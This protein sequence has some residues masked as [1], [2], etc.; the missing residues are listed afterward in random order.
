MYKLCKTEHSASR[1]REME[2]GLLQ[3][4][5]IKCYEDI[6]VS[7]LCDHLQIPR[8]SFYR[9]FSSKDGALYALLDHTMMEYEGFNA[10]YAAGDHR[11]LQKE[12]TQF[13][14]FWVHQKDLLDALSKNNMS[15]NLVER[16]LRHISNSEIIPPRFMP[17]EDNYARMQVTRFCISGMMSI[18]LTWHK[19][20]FPHS[21]EQMAQITARLVSEPLFPNLQN[22]I[23]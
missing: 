1:Q 3:L 12:L 4:M 2:K 21:A 7:D 9:Y 18:V 6:T 10:V 5:S 17:D 22:L 19:D 13:F 15:G 23:Y 8:K 14:L 11:T 20:G 16:T